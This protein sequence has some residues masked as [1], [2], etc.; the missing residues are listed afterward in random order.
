MNA[1]QIKGNS[2]QFVGKTKEK[3]GRLTDDN[4]NIVE[5]KRDRLIGK[6]QERYGIA[7]EAAQRQV[8]DFERA[9]DGL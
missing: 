3:W 6:V 9:S 4:W 2:K 8:E 7:R 1:D 5:G